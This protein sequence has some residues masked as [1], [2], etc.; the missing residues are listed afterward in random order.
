M[1]EFIA[2]LG[3]G[4]WAGSILTVAAWLWIQGHGY[5]ITRTDKLTDREADIIRHDIERVESRITNLTETD[6]QRIRA[7]SDEV[8]KLRGQE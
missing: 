7:L 4:L 5:D 1:M 3:I 2:G 6:G 8:K